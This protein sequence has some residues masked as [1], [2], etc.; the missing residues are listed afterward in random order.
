MWNWNLN[1]ASLLVVE[2]VLRVICGCRSYKNGYVWHDLCNDD[3]ILPA[4]GN[5][6]I[7]KGSELF[8]DSNSGNMNTIF[9]SGLY[10]FGINL[11]DHVLVSWKK[12]KVLY[13]G[14]LVGS[15]LYSCVKLCHSFIVDNNLHSHLRLIRKSCSR[16]LFELLCSFYLLYVKE[17]FTPFILM[18]F[19]PLFPD[20]MHNLTS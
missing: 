20:F 12:K 19:M 6:Y 9:F 13:F 16:D 4:H 15:F 10:M 8:E 5:E 3:L 7:L 2:Y 17:S 11:Y 14:V 1:S 18:E